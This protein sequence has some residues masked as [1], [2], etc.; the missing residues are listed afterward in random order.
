M[1]GSSGS[2]APSQTTTIQKSEPPAFL[3]PFLQRTATEAQR[4]FEGGAPQ[5]FP[6]QTFVDPSAETLQSLDLARQQAL[7]LQTPG[8]DAATEQI[9]GTLQGDF[10]NPFFQ[11]AFNAQVRPATD[12]F[13]EQTLPGINSAFASA[14]RLGSPAQG[15]QL[16]R[17]TDIFARNIAEVGGGLAF[18]NIENE[19]ARQ[20]QAAGLAP[21]IDTQRELLAAN[22]IQQLGQVGAARED[23][24]AL[25]LQEQ[26]QRFN[27]EQT[28]EANK[29][30]EFQSII[31]AVNLGGTTTGMTNATQGFSRNRG[32]SAFGGGLA[33]AGVGSAFGP[34]GAAIGFG[35]GALGGG[36][37]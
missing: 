5:F 22:A 23:I 25:P 14:G 17:A 35:L 9:V 6:G 31:N 27:F 24:A 37:F 4:Q 33:G 10:G 2:S 11:E 8:L 15:Q 16:N 20:L 30:R 19:R 13:L 7:G 26:I 18:Q 34:A 36:L 12:A 21:T 3:R 1:G 32:A 29:L 28:R